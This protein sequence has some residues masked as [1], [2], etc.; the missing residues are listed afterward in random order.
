MEILY[1]LPYAF[2]QKIRFLT[3]VL[4]SQR[5]ARHDVDKV[6][7]LESQE[8]IV[9]MNYLIDYILYEV[10]LMTIHL[11]WVEFEVAWVRNVENIMI[12]E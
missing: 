7:P 6:Q 10:W 8:I 4:D 12:E 5:F 3:Q 2:V 11:H 1:Q 9:Q